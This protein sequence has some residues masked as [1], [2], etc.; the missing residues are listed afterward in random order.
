M[1]RIP[2]H[3]IDIG[4]LTHPLSIGSLIRLGAELRV[5]PKAVPP[6]SVQRAGNRY[7]LLHGQQRLMVAQTEEQKEIDAI[8]EGMPDA[9]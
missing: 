7:R 3:L 1:P 4:E 5:N 9:D 6:V 8:V 2:V